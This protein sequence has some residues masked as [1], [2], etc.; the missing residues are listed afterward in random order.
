MF[1]V[2]RWFLGRVSDW[3][4]I[5]T[6]STRWNILSLNWDNVWVSSNNRSIRNRSTRFSTSTVERH[7]RSMQVP[8]EVP[9]NPTR[10]HPTRYRDW[11]KKSTAE[12]RREE[13]PMFTHS[14]RWT[15]RRGDVTVQIVDFDYIIFAVLTNLQRFVVGF[16]FPNSIEERIDLSG[17]EF[18]VVRTCSTSVE[19]SDRIDRCSSVLEDEHFSRR[20]I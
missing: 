11:K 8:N 10:S 17:R 5:D 9:R 14:T 4:L 19:R 6:G 16:I 1:H 12:W 2:C 13:I 3:S 20:S 18:I 7:F 15:F